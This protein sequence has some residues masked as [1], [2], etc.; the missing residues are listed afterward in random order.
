MSEKNAGGELWGRQHPFERTHLQRTMTLLGLASVLGVTVILLVDSRVVAVFG[1]CFIGAG[2]LSGLAA[3]SRLRYVRESRL[4]FAIVETR[5]G[6]FVLG[7][8]AGF[9]VVGLLVTLLVV[10]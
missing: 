10:R 9:V 1:V 8:A 5:D 6:R 7:S 3:A 4:G 2:V